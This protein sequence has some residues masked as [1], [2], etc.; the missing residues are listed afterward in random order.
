M[1]SGCKDW[2]VSADVRNANATFDLPD[3]GGAQGHAMSGGALTFS[4]A[5][6]LSQM[7][8]TG[9]RLSILELLEQMRQIIKEKGLMQVPQLS[10][11]ALLDLDVPFTIDTTLVRDERHTQARKPAYHHP[12]RR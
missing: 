4:I 8:T 7:I 2:Q 6:V 12:P 11:S 5:T 9:R 1:F 3:S 10:S